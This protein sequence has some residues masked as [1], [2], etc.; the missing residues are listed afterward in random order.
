MTD[1][2]LSAAVPPAVPASTSRVRVLLVDDQAIIG[3]AV[4]RMLLA[5]TDLDF[6][7]CGDPTKAMEVAAEF[8]P[9]VILQDLV[10]PEIDGLT[11]L[12]FY[13]ANPA[14]REI[15]V[16]V[17]STK[18][19]PKTKAEAFT[20]GA[21]DYL[22]NCRIRSRLIARI[23]HHSR[24]YIALVERNEAYAALKLSQQ[25]LADELNEA[26]QYVISL[27]PERL[28]GKISADWNFIPSVELGGDAF[29][30]FWLDDDHFVLYLLDVCGHGVKAALLSISAMNVIRNQTLASTDFTSPAQ[31]LAGLNEAFQMERH[32]DASR[33]SM[34]SQKARRRLAYRA[35]G[36]RPPCSC[37]RRRER[38][39]VMLANGG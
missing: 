33:C 11:M 36:I 10:M 32:T 37:R 6:Q 5:E 30:Y 13:R 16:I 39:A 7:Y 25:R 18:E 22:V 23:K 3:E 14:T 28:T 21:S 1:P 19:E 20:L 2:A 17:L 4:R 35:A 31:V 27:L 26:A 15:P 24:G 8:K 34:R 12:R 38:R 9:T 29:G